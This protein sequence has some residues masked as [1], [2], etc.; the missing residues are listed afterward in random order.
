MIISRRE[1]EVL[2]LI[3][4]EHTS[5]EIA[6]LLFISTHTVDTHRKAMMLKLNVKNTAGLI[7][8]SFEE[9]FLTIHAG[10]S[11]GPIHESQY[12]PAY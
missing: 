12:L 5:Q 9:G 10:H 3:A 4:Y 7:R 1:L 6:Q 11:S 2:K 8:K